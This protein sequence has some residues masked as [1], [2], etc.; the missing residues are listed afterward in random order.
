MIKQLL[1][2]HISEKIHPQQD[3][4]ILLSGGVD[5]LCV[6]TAAHDLGYKVVAYSFHLEDDVSYDYEKAKEVSEIMGWEFNGVI[7]PT[8]NLVDDW[9]RL[10]K[11]GCRKKVHFECVFPFLYVYPEIYQRYVLTG[12][13]A[14]GYFCNGKTA[15][16]RYSNPKKWNNHLEYCKR[17]NIKST[18]FNEYRRNYLDGDCAGYKEHT[19]LATKHGKIH[20]S[21]FLDSEVREYLMDFSWQELN[22][23]RQK[24]ILRKDFTNLEKYGKVRQHINL[25]LGSNINKL[26]ETLLLDVDINF[27]NR[28]R[29]MDVCRDWYKKDNTI[30]E[31][32]NG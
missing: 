15:V 21:P 20:I 9:H 4:A 31:F 12:W 6:A 32:M 7:V 22:I 8:S 19:A 27:N 10:V 24:E 26:F 30:E 3:V 18:T 5:S 14:D 25:H 29:M 28:K 17:M 16:M 2:N 23:P 11:L 13:G 1:E